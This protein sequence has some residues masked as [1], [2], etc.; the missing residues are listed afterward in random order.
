MSA[1]LGPLERVDGSWVVGEIRGPAGRW[2]EFRPDGLHQ[3]APDSEAEL[4][5]W[6]RIMLGI[7][8]TVGQK[9]P[10]RPMASINVFAGLPGPWR[11]RSGGCLHMTLRHPYE[12]W[13]AR[14]DRHDRWYNLTEVTLLGELLSQTVAAGEA[15]LLGD[16]DRLSRV[17]TRLALQRPRTNGAFHRAVTEAREAAG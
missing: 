1:A 5:P 6:S 12:D 9:Y 13:T 3:H 11:R 7:R 2:V 15:H 4:I 10:D 8:L 16:A 14:F 17:V